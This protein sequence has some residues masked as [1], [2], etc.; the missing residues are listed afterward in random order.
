ME[1]VEDGCGVGVGSY[2]FSELRAAAQGRDLAGTDRRGACKQLSPPPSASN[3]LIY[4]SPP[5]PTRQDHF[6]L[7]IFVQDALTSAVEPKHVP[8][9]LLSL[10]QLHSCQML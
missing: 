1:S 4:L 2:T 7:D 9:L 10:T 5:P 3:G 8:S 6:T